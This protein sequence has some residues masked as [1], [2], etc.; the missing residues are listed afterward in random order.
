ML[1]AIWQ[2][3]RK[4]DAVVSPPD[5]ATRLPWGKVNVLPSE[6]NGPFMVEAEQPEPAYEMLATR[7]SS[8]PVA[9]ARRSV[10]ASAGSAAA[11]PA[12]IGRA[13]VKR[14]IFVAL[15]CSL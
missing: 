3:L 8:G 10:W 11:R 13:V 4:L 9:A 5:R 12:R 15:F 7:T 14:C 2:F 6:A 1:R